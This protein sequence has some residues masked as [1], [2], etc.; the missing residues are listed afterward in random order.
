M[1]MVILSIDKLYL[2]GQITTLDVA[3]S[4]HHSLLA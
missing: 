3:V 2:A 4:I 1:G